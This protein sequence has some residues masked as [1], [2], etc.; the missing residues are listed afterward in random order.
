M[1]NLINS[2]LID[3][4]SFVSW[5]PKIHQKKKT[6]QE[7]IVKALNIIENA[8]WPIITLE[9]KGKNT[10]NNYPLTLN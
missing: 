1:T 6:C 5:E 3:K 9:N 2:W 7:Q 8:M 10:I 4:H